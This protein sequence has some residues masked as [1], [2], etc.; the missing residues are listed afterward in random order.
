[1]EPPLNI[2]NIYI[3]LIEITCY[4]IYRPMLALPGR[5][6]TAGFIRGSGQQ[7]KSMDTTGE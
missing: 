5:S 6:H 2:F 4:K 7:R 3:D 1:M